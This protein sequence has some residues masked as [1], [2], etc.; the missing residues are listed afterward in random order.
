[1]KLI[2]ETMYANFYVR[3]RLSKSFPFCSGVR[4]N[5]MKFRLKKILRKI[6]IMRV[7]WLRVRWQMNNSN[8][9]SNP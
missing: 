4:K 7:M 8:S 2:I 5:T 9:I 3:E 1:M 6:N